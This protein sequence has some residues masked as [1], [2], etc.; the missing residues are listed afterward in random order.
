LSLYEAGQYQFVLEG[1]N[2]TASV[3][4]YRT[5]TLVQ[6]AGDPDPVAAAPAPS[7]EK[8]KAAPPPPPP[9]KKPEPAPPSNRCASP[10]P[11]ARLEVRPARKLLRAGEE[12]EFR[13]IVFD[14][15]GCV[16]Y[17]RP[18]WAVDSGAEHAELTGPAKVHVLP[19]A[20]EG[21]VRLTA[22]V[23]G[24]SALVTIEIASSDRYDGLLR[25]GAFNA[26]GEVDEAASVA[27]ASQSIGAASA[28][29]EDRAGGRKRVF[30]A[31]V[32]VV[33]VLLAIVGV[34][35]VRRN[36]K[37]GEAQDFKDAARRERKRLQAHL[38]DRAAMP[39]PPA[40]PSPAAPPPQAAGT[41]CP[42][43]GMQY[44]AESRFCGKDGA[45]LLPLN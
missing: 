12:F 27:I 37:A 7:V 23:G 45:T 35:L 33:A 21:E 44:P 24:R 15:A 36:R 38:Q 42:I 39:A 9:E 28:V 6:R 4:R 29:A 31:F 10:G 41:L 11:A 25:S 20:P 8:L 43:C 40:A 13:A 18:T 26:A 3:G 30:V 14:G 22:S 19:D 5:Y 1:Q 17:S 32:A 2:C 16:L 34:L